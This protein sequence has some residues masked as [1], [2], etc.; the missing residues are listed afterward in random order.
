MTDS[1]ARFSLPCSIGYDVVLNNIIYLFLHNMQLN[2]SLKQKQQ[3]QEIA[4]LTA[5]QLQ[6]NPHFLFNVLQ[7]VEFEMK[8]LG[9]GAD[10]VSLTPSTKKKKFAV[11]FIFSHTIS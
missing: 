10:S 11:P 4:E 1:P 3:E 7:N 2:D 8:K 6:I 5:L 9:N